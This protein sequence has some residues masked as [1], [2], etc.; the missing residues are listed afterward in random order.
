MQEKI[1]FWSF[2]V[3][4]VC[5]ALFLSVSFSGW[6]TSSILGVHPLTI[7]LFVT[8]VTFLFGVFGFS[9]VRGWQGLARSV[10]TV[11]LTLSLSAFMGFF[12]IFG[13]LL[14]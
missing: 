13:S 5:I 6:F 7:V 2:V 10:S 1:N 4:I 9:G 8:L 12:L 11:V 14:N 3:S